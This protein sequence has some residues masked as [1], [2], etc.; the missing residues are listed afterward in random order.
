MNNNNNKFF[1]KKKTI[2]DKFDNIF[3][4]YLVRNVIYV[5][6]LIILNLFCIDIYKSIQRN[7]IINKQNKNNSLKAYK[8]KIIRYCT[9]Y[10]YKYRNKK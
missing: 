2:F 9:Y 1:F 4:I 5:Y 7:Y 10:I 3:L 8:N 6:R